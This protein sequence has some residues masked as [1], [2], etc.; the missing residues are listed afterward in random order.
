MNILRKHTGTQKTIEFI[1]HLARLAEEMAP[2][3][4]LKDAAG[5][6]T[7][8]A[9]LEGIVQSARELIAHREWLIGLENAL[10]NL[11]E[12]DF[13]LDAETLAPA[14]AAL[15]LAATASTQMELIAL[16]RK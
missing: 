1:D 6:Y 11:Y 3:Q 5:S 12:V 7:A 14:E 2:D 10:E 16:L 8:K 4:M 15:K 13:R 9:Y